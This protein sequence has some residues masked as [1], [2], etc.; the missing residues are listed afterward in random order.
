MIEPFWSIVWCFSVLVPFPSRELLAI[1]T[2]ILIILAALIAIALIYFAASPKQLAI[3]AT[4]ERNYG[5]RMILYA[6][7]LLPITAGVGFLMGLLR[8]FSANCSSAL[9]Y[10]VLATR[11]SVARNRRPLRL[12]IRHRSRARRRVTP[13]PSSP[14]GCAR[15][16]AHRGEQSMAWPSSLAEMQK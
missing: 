11:C 14:P 3:C 2:P 10:C 4:T 15:G 5:G 1:P 6:R 12:E 8:P 9:F 16:R 13:K 7:A